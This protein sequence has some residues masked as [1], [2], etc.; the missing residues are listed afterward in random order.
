MKV[1]IAD[2]FPEKS[3]NDLKALGLEVT[4]NDKLKG[5]DLAAAIPGYEVLIVRSS[6]IDA[7]II[8]AATSLKLILRAGAGTNTIDVAHANAKGIAVCNCPGTNSVAVA[9][10]AMGF[11]VALDRRIP[12]NVA[13]T[14]AGQWNKKGFSVA[15]GLAG[16]NLLIV[17]FGAIG[18][19]LATRAQAFGL[20][21]LAFDPTLTDDE[22]AQRGVERVADLFAALPRASIVSLHVPANDKTKGLCNGAFF[23][24]LP[25]GALFINTSRSEVVDEVA[26]AKAVTEK[27]L[28]AG[29]DVFNGEPE[30]KEGPFETPLAKLPGVYI[31]HH[32]GASTTQAQEAVSELAVEIV[33]VFQTSGEFLHRVN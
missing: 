3:R 6:K 12:D 20:K 29:L 11:I 13:A 26:L 30:G 21:V 7:Q 24:A 31:T 17:G 22:A 33:R 10:L 16:Q 15:T 14:R 1:L 18:H 32:I 28:R 25:A 23:D 27:G 8:D 5:A 9:E 19:A 4:F 2:E